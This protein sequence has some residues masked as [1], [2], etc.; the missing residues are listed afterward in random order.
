MP[1]ELKAQLL[2]SSGIGV[3]RIDPP[4][5]LPKELDRWAALVRH[6]AALAWTGR[7]AAVVEIPMSGKKQLSLKVAGL[8]MQRLS[9]R[10]VWIAQVLMNEDV[11]LDLVSTDEFELTCLWFTALNV[12]DRNRL[13]ALCEAFERSG[14]YV[15]ETAEEVMFC[16]SDGEL[17][18]WTHP[19]PGL[20]AAADAME[21]AA[22]S[23][24]FELDVSDLGQ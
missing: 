9:P 7:T 4:V 5:F 21:L 20:A 1:I 19:N 14:W 8:D 17:V 15:P 10:N 13:L 11:V 24:G 12:T 18:A 23:Q 16:T 6:W 22:R 3:R 2:G